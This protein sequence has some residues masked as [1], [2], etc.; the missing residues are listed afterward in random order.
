MAN[1]MT[2]VETIKAIIEKYG[3]SGEEKTFLEHEIELIEKR[4]AYKSSKPTKKQ[5]ENDALAARL[6]E[7]IEEDA[8]YTATD[9]A[10]MMGV[11]AEGNPYSPQKMSSLLKKLKESGEVVTGTIKR[12]TYFGRP[13]ANF[14]GIVL[15]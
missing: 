11:D 15:G 7:L 2:K 13:G 1:K 3:V 5:V 14:E 6:L 8:C 4:N 12:R 10:E 9:L